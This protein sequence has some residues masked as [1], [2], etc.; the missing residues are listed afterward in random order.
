MKFISLTLAALLCSAAPLVSVE[1]DKQTSEQAQ[2]ANLSLNKEFVSQVR[3]QYAAGRYQEFLKQ[4]DEDY[5]KVKKDAALDG[6]IALRKE[7]AL[8]AAQHEKTAAKWNEMAQSW[9]KERNKELSKLIDTKDSSPIAE[10]VRSAME[11]IN[12][13]VEETLQY[14]FGLRN[15]EPGHGK[16]SD[17]NQLIER[18]LELEYKQMHLDSIK[19][20]ERWSNDTQ[21]K[22]F[23]L[24]LDMM[25]KMIADSKNFQDKELQKKVEIL[26][27]NLD[28]YY[29]RQLDLRD[30]HRLATGVITPTSDLEKKVAAILAAFEGKFSEQTQAIIQQSPRN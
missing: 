4:M 14:F 27:S 16:N 15:I 7:D 24:R 22:R 23:A 18:D 3:S 25:D 5:A 17:E 21:E 28:S 8:M 19:I 11:Q 30:L 13:S 20:H 26:A 2:S 12:P 6:L 29:A 9:A 1:T 10:K